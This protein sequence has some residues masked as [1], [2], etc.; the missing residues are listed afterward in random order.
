MALRSSTHAARY[1]FWSALALSVIFWLENVKA[2]AVLEKWS[3]I[4]EKYLKRAKSLGYVCTPY[5]LNATEYGVS[6]K[7][8]RVFFVGIREGIGA[9]FFNYIKESKNQFTAIIIRVHFTCY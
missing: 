6:Q 4:R 7:R 1:F 9:K 8:E 5:V 2:L 3:A